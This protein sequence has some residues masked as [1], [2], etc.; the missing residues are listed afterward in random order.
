ML[1]SENDWYAM[2]LPQTTE[3]H[4]TPTPENQRLQST[5]T[6]VP[7]PDSQRPP[8]PEISERPVSDTHKIIRSSS[9]DHRADLDQ[10]QRIYELRQ[11]LK[12]A[13]KRSEELNIADTGRYRPQHV[14]HLR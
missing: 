10:A 5:E 2:E 7:A 8:T 9:L 14:I 13:K 12:K 4:V 6:R 1:D 11:R 3:G